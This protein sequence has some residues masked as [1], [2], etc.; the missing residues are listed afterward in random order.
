MHPQTTQKARNQSHRTQRCT[1]SGLPPP[2]GNAKKPE[3]KRTTRQVMCFG[4]GSVAQAQSM[5]ISGYSLHSLQYTGILTARVSG[6]T[7]IRFPL[8]RG[9]LIC[10]VGSPTIPILP[11]HF[12]FVKLPPLRFPTAIIVPPPKSLH[13]PYPSTHAGPCSHFRQ[14]RFARAHPRPV[15]GNN[16]SVTTIP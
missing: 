7:R 13:C 4:S 16:S 5:F 2:L 6:Y 10:T 11:P 3:P 15:G 12:R 9:H 14:Y 8:H 1:G